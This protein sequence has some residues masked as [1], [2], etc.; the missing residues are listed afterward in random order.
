MVRSY[1]FAYLLG[2]LTSSS[3]AEELITDKSSKFRIDSDRVPY[4]LFKPVE[5]FKVTSEYYAPLATT[6]SAD[7]QQTDFLKRDASN[8]IL[9]VWLEKEI[10][11]QKNNSDQ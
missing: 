1:F 7:F 10:K 6:K 9:K 5:D 3:Y 11:K 8:P 4:L 2:H